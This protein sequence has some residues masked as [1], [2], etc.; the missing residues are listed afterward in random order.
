MNFL[1]KFLVA[2]LFLNISISYSQEGAPT[3]AELQANFQQYQSCATNVPF[4][5][6][7]G[8]NSEN[9][10]T[11]CIGGAFR[12]PTWF[13]IEIQNS[14][15]IQLQ[16]SQVDNFGGGTDVDFVLWGPFNDLNNICSKL[17]ITKEVDCSYSM[18]SIEAVNLPNG[19]AG[20]LYVLLV[21]N[22]SN[23]PG[24][25]SITQTGGTGSSNCD[26]L[27]SVKIV[28]TSLNEITQLD[29]C[30]PSTKDLVA[31]IDIS[32]FPGLPAN[33]RFNY[34]WY[35]DNVLINSITDSTSNTNT[36][37]VTDSGVYK[38]ETTAYDSTD[39]TV[40]IANLTVSEDD[41]NLKF[42]TTPTVSIANTNTRCLN[43]NPVLQSTITN[44]TTL[45][46]AV[47]VLTYQWFLNGAIIPG[48]VSANYTPTQPGD[49]FVRIF[50][51]PC[52]TVDSNVIHI[53]ANPSVVI[54][55]N[56][57]ICEG[58]IYTITSNI[59][60]S[61]LLTTVTFQWL[62]DANPI[63]GAT[64]PTYTV[65]AGNQSLNTT[66]VYTLQVT[67]QGLCSILSNS[68]SITVN[69]L[70]VVNTTPIVLEQC[71]YIAPSID[72][73]A[74]INLT[75]A[76]NAITNN[77]AGLT[78]Y[79]YQDAGLTIPI[80][81]PANY[82]NVT[83][84]LQNVYVKA[85]N[86][87]VTPNCPSINTATINLIINPTSV[88]AYPNMAAVCPEVNQNYGRIDFNAQRIIIKNTFFPTSP[89]DI[90]FYINTNDASV[91]ANALTNSSNIP[92]GIHTIYTRI[93]TNNNCDGIGE[94]QVE[95]SA[96]PLQN[97]MTGVITCES[98]TFILNTKDAEA[99]LGQ[100]PSVQ[101][102]YFHSFNDAKNNLNQIDKNIALPLTVGTSNIYIKLYDTTT[103]CFSIVNFSLRVFPDP[104]IFNPLPIRLCG[105]NTATFNLNSRI[106]A[107]TGGNLNYQVSFYETNADLLANNF[108]AT[109]LNYTSG[110]RTLIVK[111]VDPTNNGCDKLT[112]LDLVV[113]SIPGATIN[114]TPLEVCND[115]GFAQF[116][117]TSRESEMA[118]PT[119]L[120][121][122]E[123]SYYVNLG[124]ALV[125]NNNNI[126][127]PGAFTNTIINFQ[128]I[129]VRLNSKSN[130]NSE[131]NIACHTILELDIYVR[132][133]P[134]NNLLNE[135]YIICIDKDK[136]PA[137]P[138]YIDTKLSSSDYRF[139]W[140]TGFGAIDGNEI[141][142]ETQPFY[143][144]LL[145][146]EYSVKIT[147][148]SVFTGLDLCSTT[149]D[150]RTLNSYIPFSIKG[151]PSEL[152][153]FETENTITAV[154]SPPSSDYLYSLNNTGLQ[155]SNVFTNI[156]EGEYTLT[157][158]NKYGCGEISTQIIVVDYPKYFTPNGD[159]FHDTWNIGGIKALDSVVIQ[160]YDRHGK[161][162]KQMDP[163]NTGWNGTFNG[164]ALPATDYWFKIIYEKDNV[165][166]E[167]KGH[168]TLKR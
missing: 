26:F 63:A 139:K 93:E 123:F 72:G 156:L 6:S 113:L 75:Q 52:I 107:I 103:Q 128:K 50:N 91:E 117:L 96:A 38:V 39:P 71:D 110:T 166:N 82:T 83:P 4:Q 112:T 118:G 119:A 116:D 105:V 137:N 81:N 159:G 133:Y 73:I 109:P 54:N 155:T 46:T 34:K 130:F 60:N 120:T 76:Y 102:S 104:T 49:Y 43:N 151:E 80:L 45:N 11:T 135:P 55:S 88:S 131:T 15:N 37:T 149:V 21:D 10:N 141:P 85:I 77:I 32:D 44:I 122:I 36:L 62:K 99:L 165:K 68:V 53:V 78:L 145:E 24:N 134:V 89:V 124:D 31:K 164:I 40:V 138:A 143:E 142:G 101:T 56:Q 106:T 111:V 20:Q 129:Y 35:K 90:Q 154:V 22:Y 153:A 61:A 162:I 1:T 95:V 41:I 13:Y 23:Q 65:S 16:I 64:N 167:F 136:V 150:F 25:I 148:I 144:A 86:E 74:V 28:D 115:S 127:T 33:L 2:L 59:T 19:I 146:G 67:E 140:Y 132:S 30:K 92:V 3:C 69:A 5:N 7:T 70:P 97:A 66:S 84:F 17:N 161:F 121:D 100:N 48:A 157:V 126:T 168:F 160:I 87:N 12:G 8:G 147:S 47:D 27:S 152:I 98:D 163:Y 94:F 29:Y 108:I 18:S 9:F 114:P 57:T 42:H 51:N 14:G 158:T 58:S 79:Y 125:N